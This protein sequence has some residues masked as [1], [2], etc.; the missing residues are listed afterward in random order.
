MKE[1]WEVKKLGEVCEY[2]KEQGNY[3]DLPYVGMEDIEPKTGVFI[4][5][6]TPKVVASS[7]FRFFAGYVLFGR[8]RPYLRKTLIPNFN[9]HCST[10]IFPIKPTN[11]LDPR[12]LQYWFGLD[13]T[14][15][16][17]N[18]TCTGAR[19]PR[20]NMNQVLEIKIP[21]PNLSEQERIVGIL[22]IAFAKIEVLRCNAEK[23]LQ[24]TKALFQATLK[25]ELT[26][27]GISTKII[28]DL[29]NIKTGKLNS[30]ASIENGKYPFFTC[31]R[32]IFAINEYAFDCEAILLAGNNASGDFN[33]KHYHGKFNAYQRTY[34]I[35][36]KYKETVCRLLYY[37]LEN[38]L[39]KLK[40]M[41]IGANTKFLKIGMIENVSIIDVSSFEQQTIVTKLD[42]LSECCKKM[43][44]NYNQTIAHCNAL[45]QAL[46]KKAFNGEL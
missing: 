11:S 39:S 28:K 7:T 1:G 3:N 10:E 33:V 5:D 6:L 20:A 35:T 26:P 44:E 42:A 34:V 30:N 14:N 2:I 38:Y 37:V 19:M 12:F 24:N 40:S 23:N 46:L 31:S 18:D 41:S 13:L 45:K 17:I 43:E 32:S 15:S 21:L 25:Q 9:G 4:G 8:L 16:V 22:D 36:T 29:Y 27:K